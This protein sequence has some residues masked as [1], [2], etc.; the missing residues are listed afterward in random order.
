LT[1][2]PGTGNLIPGFEEGIL[3]MRVGEKA[4]LVLPSKIAYGTNGN[5]TI[6]P[7]S[8]LY[9]EVEVVGVL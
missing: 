3:K 9:F 1:F 5:S 2:V 6:P 7:N 8:P 4:A